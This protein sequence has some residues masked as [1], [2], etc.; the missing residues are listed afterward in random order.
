M[1]FNCFF[2][3]FGDRGGEA[4][5]RGATQTL[6]IFDFIVFIVFLEPYIVFLLFFI[7]FLLSFL[8]PPQA[9]STFP[10]FY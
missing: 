4:A 7:A 2:Y 6:E 9:V 5:G 3:R 8:L 10:F 1:F